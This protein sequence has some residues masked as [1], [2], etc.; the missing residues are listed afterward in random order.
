MSDSLKPPGGFGSWL[1][2]AIATMDTRRL[3]LESCDEGSPWG[4]IVQSDEMRE[5]ARTELRM[6]GETVN[7]ELLA[8]LKTADEAICSWCDHGRCEACQDTRHL[9]RLALIAKAEGKA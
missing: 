6:M 1:E 9:A 3:H 8:A 2:Y 4:R 7:A 5:A